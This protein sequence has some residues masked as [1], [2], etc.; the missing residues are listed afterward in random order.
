MN[1]FIDTEFSNFPWLEDCEFI[2]IGLYFENGIEYYSCSSQFNESNVSE[3][4]SNNVVANLPENHLRKS[5]FQIGKDISS[6][7]IKNPVSAVWAIFPTLDQLSKFYNGNELLALIFKRYA[8]FD[9]QLLLNLLD[10]STRVLLPKSCNDL[11]PIAQNLK[12][13]KIPKNKCA[14]N[15]LEDA[16]WNYRVWQV[17]QVPNKSLHRKFFGCAKKFR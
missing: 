9:F 11:S 2:S 8:D 16:K 12:K 6:L 13:N 7:L 10:Q 1:L 15:A 17:S 3:F 5:N 4:V 14:H